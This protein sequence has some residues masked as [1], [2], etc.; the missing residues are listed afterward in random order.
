MR[1][2]VSWN[3]AICSTTLS[4]SIT[5]IAP[6]STSMIS[7]RVTTATYPISPPSVTLPMSPMKIRAG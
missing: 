2:P 1:L 3:E 4:P 6:T 5:K 7:C